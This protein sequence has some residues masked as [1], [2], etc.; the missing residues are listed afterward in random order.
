MASG[1]LVL[2]RPVDYHFVTG[3]G[4]PHRPDPPKGGSM[5][6]KLSLLLILLTLPAVYLGLAHF[7]GGAYPTLGLALGGDRAE[8]RQLALVSQGAHMGR[9]S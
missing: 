5:K 9:G 3:I 2:F 7:S 8:L 4:N 1:R 6:K